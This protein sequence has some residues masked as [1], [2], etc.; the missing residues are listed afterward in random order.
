MYIFR[1]SCF[2]FVD[3]QIFIHLSNPLKNYLLCYQ[4]S[5]QPLYFLKKLFFLTF[6]LIPSFLPSYL[7]SFTNSL[8]YLF[9]LCFQI[10][11]LFNS[12]H[13]CE[14]SSHSLTKKALFGRDRKQKER[15]WKREREKDR[16]R[17]SGIRNI[18]ERTVKK[19]Q[20]GEEENRA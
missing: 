6:L 12:Q 3:I 10:N 20:N 17:E 5:I 14:P 15:D 1:D 16:I 18:A 4:D 19:G 7:F 2:I 11:A 9:L 8:R 13:F